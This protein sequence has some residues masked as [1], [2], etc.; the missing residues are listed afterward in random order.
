MRYRRCRYDRGEKR[1]GCRFGLGFVAVLQDEEVEETELIILWNR[2]CFV[3]GRL[4]E[5]G[6]F[7][8]QGETIIWFPAHD[9]RSARYLD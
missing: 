1:F 3:G 4:I 8:L 9:E 2:K 5:R 6:K 7:R